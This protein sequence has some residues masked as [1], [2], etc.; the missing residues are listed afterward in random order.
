M[1]QGVRQGNLFYILDKQTTTLQTGKVVGISNPQLQ[2]TFPTTTQT[3]DITVD[4]DGQIMEFKK[5]NSALSIAD[6]GQVVVSDSKELMTQEVETQLQ[7][8]QQALD[9]IDYHKQVVENCN[10]ILSTLNPRLAKEKERDEDITN[11]KMQMSGVESKVDQILAALA[12]S[13]N[14]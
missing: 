9:K 8:S 3:V 11:L 14:K 12:S 1:F 6:S 13:N 2:S 5:L 10:I 7:S 4:V